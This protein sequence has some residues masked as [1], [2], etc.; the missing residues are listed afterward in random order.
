MTPSTQWQ[1]QVLPG[2]QEHL[3]RLANELLDLQRATSRG[4]K[5]D[6]ALH[7]KQQAAVAAEFEVLD[8][9]PAHA[10]VGPFAKPARYRTW[11]RFSNGSGR[12]QTDR[13]PDV[14]GV[15]LKLVG[16]EGRKVIDGLQDALTQDFLLVRN[17]A[18][19]FASA[20]DFVWLVKAAATTPALLPLKA[21]AR[22]GPVRGF[23]F[24][25]GLLN[26]L[27]VPATSAAT[28]RYYG[29]LPIRFGDYAVKYCLEPHARDDGALSSAPDAFG[30]DLA[31]RLREGPVTYDFR[32]QFFR[33]EETTPIEDAS[34]EWLETDSPFLTVGRLVIPKQELASPR[35]AAVA[36]F[37][38]TLS[39]DP[40]HC[41]EA[42][43]PLGQMMRARNVAYRLSTL[44]R[45]AA[46]EPDGTERLDEEVA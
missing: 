34:K 45:G 31:A 12:R 21:L 24:L 39:F 43:R 6:R 15:A 14:R 38:D 8:I 46:R 32:I 20:D 17:P 41:V 29:A 27:R 2:E 7:A 3:T 37:V 22:F 33:D 40:W 36:R 13:A 18:L 23:A 28:T 42:L 1:E 16:V 44:E 30:D 11:V 26:S 4:G 10:R 9:L 35:G 19:P 25:R 5:P